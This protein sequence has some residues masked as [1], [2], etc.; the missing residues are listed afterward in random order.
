LFSENKELKII[1]LKTPRK[2]KCVEQDIIRPLHNST[3]LKSTAFFEGVLLN[4]YNLLL[5]Q[6]KYNNSQKPV[7][8]FFDLFHL[9]FKK[10]V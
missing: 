7:K 8:S 3:I 10:I 1:Y 5:N 6:L 2:I 4:L 9:F